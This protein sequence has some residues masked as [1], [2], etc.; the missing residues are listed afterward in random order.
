[1]PRPAASPLRSNP[2]SLRCTWESWA[3]NDEVTW[4]PRVGTGV[5]TGGAS[6]S[7]AAAA[8]AALPVARGSGVPRAAALS[9]TSPRAAAYVGAW[10]E[11]V[12]ASLLIDAVG[13]DR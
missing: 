4:S 9:A 2:A 11:R 12:T 5:R 6:W 1:M 3:T 10:G 7:W 13:A 8:M